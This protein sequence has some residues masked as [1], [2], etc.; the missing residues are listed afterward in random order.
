MSEFKI[1][2]I[3]D[4]SGNWAGNAMVYDTFRL[5]EEAAGD[6]ANRWLLVTKARVVEYKVLSRK[7]DGSIDAI[8]VVK[9]TVVWPGGNT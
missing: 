8:E 6:L 5:A 3:A 2:V 7:G 1:E 4:S 9:D